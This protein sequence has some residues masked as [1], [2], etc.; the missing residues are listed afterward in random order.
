MNFIHKISNWVFN[1]EKLLA[2]ILCTLMLSSLF[3]GVVFRYALNAPLTWS[4]ETA[5]FSLVWLTFIG[6]SMGIKSQKSA[7]I[8]L[9][10]DKFHGKL[11]MILMAISILALL[12]FVVYIFYLSVI[13]LSSP[14]VLLQKSNSMQ[15][16][17]IIAYLSVPVSFFF[18]FIHSLDLLLKNFRQEKEA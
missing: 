3:A 7:V 5:I 10:M 4:E 15:M 17:M 13:W 14:T 1:I 12:L 11:R 6:G 9:F 18:I 2:I 8:T 16:P